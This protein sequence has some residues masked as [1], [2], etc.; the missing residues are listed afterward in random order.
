MRSTNI[1]LFPSDLVRFLS[2]VNV[3]SSCRWRR[4][5]DSAIAWFTLVLLYV[6]IED[7]S[8]YRASYY[9]GDCRD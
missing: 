3:N 9:E 4:R 8:G 5:N 6:R 2:S 7:V 1:L